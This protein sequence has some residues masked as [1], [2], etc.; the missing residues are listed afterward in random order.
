VI[1]TTGETKL[2]WAFGSSDDFEDQHSQRGTG[3]INFDEGTFSETDI[4][5]LWIFHAALMIIGYSMM[6]VGV[7]FAKFYR[8]KKWWLKRHKLLGKLGAGLSVAGLVS[9]F[10]MVSLSSGEHFRVPHAYV[11][12][13]A[14]IFAVMTPT[15]GIAQFKVKKKK[16]KI[17]TFHRWFG[18]ITLV[19]M[20]I[21]I[22]FGLNL[23]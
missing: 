5:S 12:V 10:V 7:I 16:A 9:A 23:V 21:N 17:R 2:I 15:L 20:F 6:L 1:S 18:R 8:K 4:P 13:V 3:A 14:I 22:V 11:G 19:V